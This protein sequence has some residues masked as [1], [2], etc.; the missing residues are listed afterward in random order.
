MPPDIGDTG[1]VEITRISPTG[2]AHV[3]L[4]D[5]KH[6][7]IGYIDCSLGDS[8]RVE[9]LDEKYC[10]SLDSTMRGNNYLERLSKMREHD[11]DVE[12]ASEKSKYV[13]NSFSSTSEKSKPTKNPF[14]NGTENKNN[15]I[16][17]SL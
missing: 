6:L 2:N 9:R 16:N 5:K 11:N 17:G 7:N 8:V 3:E 15:L 10:K 13:K 1:T 12:Y 4:S 14:N